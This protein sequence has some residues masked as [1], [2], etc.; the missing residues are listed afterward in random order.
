MEHHAIAGSYEVIAVSEGAR[1]QPANFPELLTTYR[2][3]E[4]AVSIL[5]YTSYWAVK[6]GFLLFYRLIFGVSEHF[7]KA[8]WIVLVATAVLYWVPIAGVLTACGATK[9]IDN[10]G[11]LRGERIIDRLDAK[12][13]LSRMRIGAILSEKCLDILLRCYRIYRRA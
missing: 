4:T 13:F 10:N 6:V 9:N 1:P 8:W 5:A 7:M 2:K 11:Q 12:F 3:E